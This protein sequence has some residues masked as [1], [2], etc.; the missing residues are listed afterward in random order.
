MKA[1]GQPKLSYP[2]GERAR[3]DEQYLELGG[4]PDIGV[5]VSFAGLEDHH[6]AVDRIVLTTARTHSG[7]DRYARGKCIPLVEVMKGLA[8]V[9]TS[10]DFRARKGS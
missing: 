2:M 1:A 9:M 8:A 10:Q 4:L 7:P 6:P 3:I 5:E